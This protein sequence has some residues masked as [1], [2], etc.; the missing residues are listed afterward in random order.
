VREAA[1]FETWLTLPDVH[2]GQLVTMT[3][4]VIE[5]SGD[6]RRWFAEAARA[7]AA[8][9]GLPPPPLSDTDT[10]SLGADGDPMIVTQARRC[11]RRR[12]SPT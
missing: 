11:S 1:P 7:Y 12:A 10:R 5:E 4:E 3:L 6:R 2:R 9:L 8:A